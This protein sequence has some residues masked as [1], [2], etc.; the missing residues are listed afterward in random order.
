MNLREI[1]TQDA[2]KPCARRRISQ[3][4]GE[5]LKVKHLEPIKKVKNGDKIIGKL[6]LTTSKRLTLIHLQEYQSHQ[7]Q[8][9]VVHKRLQGALFWTEG[10]EQ[11]SVVHKRLQG[12]LIWTEGPEEP[13]G[14]PKP[15]A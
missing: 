1:D 7:G 12:A 4:S 9:S 13:K 3:T 14:N 10:P 15:R 11:L 8:L 5:N 6:R 2:S